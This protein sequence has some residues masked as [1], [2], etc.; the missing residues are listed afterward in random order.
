MR[1]HL[2]IERHGLPVTRILWTTEAPGSQRPRLGPVASA[3]AAPSATTLTSSRH[4]N[5]ALGANGS[6]TAAGSGGLTIAQLLEDV[7]NVVPLQTDGTSNTDSIRSSYESADTDHS[8][9]FWT[10]EDYVV[11]VAGSECLHFMAVDGILRDEDEVV[12]RALQPQELAMR[13]ATGRMQINNHGW[14]LIDGVPFGHRFRSSHVGAR[15]PVRIP[16][17]KRRRLMYEPVTDSSPQGYMTGVD[18]DARDG[19]GQ[20]A[21]YEG[22]GQHSD[23]DYDDDSDRDSDADWLD[24]ERASNEVED[25]CMREFEDDDVSLAGNSDEEDA[26]LIKP[27]SIP[28][29]KTEQRSALE[30]EPPATPH[31]PHHWRPGMKPPK[32]ALKKTPR[33][34]A[35]ARVTIAESPSRPPA[36]S[37]AARCTH[38][39]RQK[40]T[41]SEARGDESDQSSSSDE[42]ASTASSSSSRD[43][44]PSASP[45]SSSSQSSSQ[46]SSRASSW[47][48]SPS[49]SDNGS[50]SSEDSSDESD[51]DGAEGAARS[52]TAAR[53]SKTEGRQVRGAT[54]DETRKQIS[55]APAPPSAQTAQRHTP[56]G[57]GSVNTRYSNKRSKQRRKLAR[58]KAAGLLPE[59]ANFAD[60]LHWEAENPFGHPC[61]A[62]AEQPP[63]QAKSHNDG[64]TAAEPR[65]ETPHARKHTGGQGDAA[66]TEAQQ[67]E[68]EVRRARLLEAIQA[69]GVD[70]SPDTTPSL[71]PASDQSP[72]SSTSSD[73]DSSD[74]SSDGEAP[75]KQPI[76]AQPSSKMAFPPRSMLLAKSIRKASTKPAAAAVATA[77]RSGAEQSLPA[78]KPEVVGQSDAWQSKLVVGAT[79]CVHDHISLKPPPFP[80]KQRWDKAA[81]RAIF[82]EI[83]AQAAPTTT[84][85]TGKRKRGS[86]QTHSAETPVPETRLSMAVQDSKG[87][88]LDYGDAPAAESP[89]PSSQRSIPEDDTIPP[90]PADVDT[91]P[92]L[93]LP[94]LRQGAVI[95]YKQME[96]SSEAPSVSNR[97]YTGR[98]V[99][100]S[101]IEG[102]D[103]AFTLRL[104][105]RDRVEMQRQREES[106]WSKFETP[107]TAAEGEDDKEADE[108]LCEL[109]YSLLI[110]SR[111][112]C[113]A[114]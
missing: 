41:D 23:G 26:L 52:K 22:D 64:Q 76:Q 14:H 89:L 59:N 92:P 73:S 102:D 61:L 18:E 71:A 27:A 67:A 60:L 99:R 40:G 54:S 31:S 79:E 97:F 74:G 105:K 6:L 103:V 104:A 51:S 85:S 12:I 93:A 90:L 55:C 35:H 25:E 15:P 20:L 33:R 66:A 80:F 13:R 2:V 21:L 83:N 109:R 96:L 114:T 19:S 9:Q 112:V 82:A 3:Y 111:L 65:D 4:A 101:D 49:T 72:S 16:P 42:N 98:V 53:K 77:P 47:S 7:D 70:V 86:Q 56:P 5:A 106:V 58:L 75:E 81:D 94:H 113:L 95:A 34:N 29:N 11:E 1:L 32:S 30:D 50:S 62:G 88:G 44:S 36:L 110:D 68:F 108:G 48:P 24:F 38:G 100:T 87:A 91:L 78:A 10:L 84:Q 45:S 69:G 107:A 28:V 39:A 37:S 57:Q 63:A 43:S 8:G 46:S 17:R